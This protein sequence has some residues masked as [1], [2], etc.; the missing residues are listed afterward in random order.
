VSATQAKGALTTAEV[1]RMATEWFH[2][3]D[4]HAPLEDFAEFLAEDGLE[5]RFPEGVSRGWDGFKS[6]YERVTRIFFDEAHQLKKVAATP[7][8]DAMNV[9]V[10][11]NWQ[12]S[13]WKPP[14]PRSERIVLDAFQ[15]WVVKRSPKTG[16]PVIVTYIVDRLDYAPGSARL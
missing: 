15:T 4:V 1:E 16:K 10:V 13:V 11:V 2:K 3:L 5:L 12:A 9:Q 14:A 6:W 8:G 7:S